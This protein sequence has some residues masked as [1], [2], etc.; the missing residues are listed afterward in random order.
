MELADKYGA[1]YC[2]FQSAIL[3]VGQLQKRNLPV[4]VPPLHTQI[5]RFIATGQ[6][7]CVIVVEVNCNMLGLVSCYIA[8]SF[9]RC[10]GSYPSTYCSTV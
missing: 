3:F 2:L 9:D 4:T 5:S 6:G 8:N 1:F 10:K 7:L